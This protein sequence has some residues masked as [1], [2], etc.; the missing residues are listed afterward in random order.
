MFDPHKSSRLLSIGKII[1][2]VHKE[3][4]LEMITM[5][6]MLFIII[7]VALQYYFKYVNI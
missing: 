1:R 6:V 7:M 4:K 5:I 3:K 2:C